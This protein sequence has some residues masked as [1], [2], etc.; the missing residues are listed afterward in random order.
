MNVVESAGGT[1]TYITLN[2]H[3]IIKAATTEF[4]KGCDS[5]VPTPPYFPFTGLDSVLRIRQIGVPKCSVF[6]LH[7]PPFSFP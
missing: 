1:F 5:T 2:N 7:I 6:P 3:F 4:F